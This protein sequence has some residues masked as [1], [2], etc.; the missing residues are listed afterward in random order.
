[1]LLPTKVRLTL[2][3]WRYLFPQLPP[4]QC[5][6]FVLIPFGWE[7]SLYVNH[8][9]KPKWQSWPTIS[10]MSLLKILFGYQGFLHGRC[11]KNLSVTRCHLKGLR[12]VPESN[13]LTHVLRG[14][15]LK[16]ITSKED[17]AF[18]HIITWKNVLSASRVRVELIRWTGCCVFVAAGYQ[19]KHPDWCPRLTPDHSCHH[20]MF[21]DRLQNL[22]HQHWSHAIFDDESRVRLYH[23]DRVPTN[24][25]CFLD[26]TIH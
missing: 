23:S 21:K 8:L 3:T 6:A 15:L 26:A 24:S 16:T 22:N 17:H 20:S 25:I 13:S 12:L 5:G 18:L 2:E 7:P 4:K 9:L 19:S 10:S 11:R 14:H 1:M